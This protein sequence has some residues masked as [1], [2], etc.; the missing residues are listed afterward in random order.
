MSET[1]YALPEWR[2]HEEPMLSLRAFDVKGI[3]QSPDGT[4]TRMAF[5]GIFDAF[6]NVELVL[7]LPACRL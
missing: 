2:V 3:E 4:T 5:H 1:E 7:F 6:V